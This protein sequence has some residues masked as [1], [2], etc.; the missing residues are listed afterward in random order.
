MA[1]RVINKIMLHVCWIL[2]WL[3][4]TFQ[5]ATKCLPAAEK[6]HKFGPACVF[7]VFFPFS[8][9]TTLQYHWL[10][11]SLSNKSSISLQGICHLPCL[12]HS[13]SSQSLFSSGYF[14][15]F[16]SEGKSLPFRGFWLSKVD[17]P[18]F[19]PPTFVYIF[20]APITTWNSIFIACLLLA[21]CLLT[22]L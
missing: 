22:R 5:I 9:L 13:F 8:F 1:S 3:P 17:F 6:S 16:R 11:F 21:V 2:S 18:C 15:I 10:S 12:R 20:I 4:I 19:L 7:P 14:S